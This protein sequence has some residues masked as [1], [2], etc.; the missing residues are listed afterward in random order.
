[1]VV[2][3]HSPSIYVATGNLDFCGHVDC[4]ERDFME[5]KSIAYADVL[6]SPTQYM[7]CWAAAQGWDLPARSYVQPFTL[8]DEFIEEA[9]PEKV[10][11]KELVFF[12]RMQTKHTHDFNF[13]KCFRISVLS[14]ER[15]E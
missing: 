4:L 9:R 5:R 15:A 8:P 1:M 11:I 14:P 13:L 2:D 7:I 10:K 6:L 3:V 12:G